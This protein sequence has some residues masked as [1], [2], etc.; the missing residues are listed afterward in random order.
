[1]S[2]FPRIRLSFRTFSIFFWAGIVG[3]LTVIF[4]VQRYRELHEP[5]LQA[6][7]AV[8]ALSVVESD[9]PMDPAHAPIAAATAAP[10][11]PP[12]PKAIPPIERPTL[13]PGGPN[14]DAPPPP[15]PI[16]FHIRNL[17]DQGRIEGEVRNVSSTP[18]SITMQAIN[19]STGTTSELQLILAPGQEKNYSTEEG[20]VMAAHDQLILRSLGFQ[21]R[22][23]K[24]P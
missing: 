19:A 4:F 6:A 24:V 1:M 15:L 17:R 18:L 23:V 11:D 13:T 14:A 2:T 16:A 21:D 7:P 20:L 3:F 5:S 8:E 12:Q 10:L 9:S 22:V